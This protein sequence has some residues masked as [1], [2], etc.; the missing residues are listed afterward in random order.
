M[1]Q[2]TNLVV[3]EGNMSH[4]Y[5]LSQPDARSRMPAGFVVAK[6]RC[7]TFALCGIICDTSLGGSVRG[8]HDFLRGVGLM[9]VFC[10]VTARTR[11]PQ[12]A[13]DRNRQGTQ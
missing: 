1:V 9:S 2:K 5:H 8:T 3:P 13:V 10:T 11:I 7:R 6:L 4:K 12:V